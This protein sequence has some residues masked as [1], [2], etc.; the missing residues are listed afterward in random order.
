MT[1]TQRIQQAEAD[2]LSVTLDPSELN[3]LNAEIDDWI[4]MYR[5]AANWRDRVRRVALEARDTIRG[6]NHRSPV[7]EKITRVCRGEEIE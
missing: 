4:S 7:V 2:G 5:N 3:Q 6:Y 1:I